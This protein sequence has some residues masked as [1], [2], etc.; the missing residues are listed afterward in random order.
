MT[1]SPWQA[2]VAAVAFVGTGWRKAYGALALALAAAAAYR[3]AIR[4]DRPHEA[5]WAL[6]IGLLIVVFTIMSS[7]A[8]YRTALAQDHQGDPGFRP[9]PGGLQWDRRAWRLLGGLILCDVIWGGLLVFVIVAWA[10]ALGA[11]VTTRQIAPADLEGLRSFKAFWRL[12]HGPAG[13]ASLAVLGP[14]GLAVLFVYARFSLLPVMAL[15]TGDFGLTRAISLTRGGTLAIMLGA[16]VI[17]AVSLLVSL[18]VGTAA[19]L[20]GADTPS[21]TGLGGAFWGGV[22]GS[23]LG[24]AFTMPAM[25]GLTSCV[26]RRGRGDAAG[27]ASAFS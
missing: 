6:G 19:G 1:T 7:A 26:Y 9:A 15:E 27:V 16:V 8:L 10:F 22:V 24:R 11:L 14:G 23:A 25:A 2:L 17:G 18:A 3:V 20:V 5:L 13:L 21:A 12:M 4:L